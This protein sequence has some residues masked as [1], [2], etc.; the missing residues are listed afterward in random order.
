MSQELNLAQKIKAM[1]VGHS[2]TVKTEYERQKATRAA[3]TL[4]D[5]GIINFEIITKADENGGFKVA[6]I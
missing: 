3:K 5:A 6:A 2:F 4:R 1:K